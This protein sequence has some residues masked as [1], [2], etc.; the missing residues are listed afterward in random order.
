MS[1]ENK[2]EEKPGMFEKAESTGAELI[3]ELGYDFELDPT[4]EEEITL[5]RVRLVKRVT[6]ADS[7]WA[8]EHARTVFKIADDQDPTH[9]QV[10][11]MK[12][13]RV[14]K[15]DEKVFTCVDI[16]ELPDGFLSLFISKFQKF[17][18]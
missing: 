9:R 12:L 14:A 13:S 6:V 8:E 5:P 2:T 1:D 16:M 11:I 7:L 18:M 3:D 17:L 15:F 4:F 10:M